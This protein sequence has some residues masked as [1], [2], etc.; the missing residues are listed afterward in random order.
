MLD[1]D[2]QIFDKEPLLE[3]E[4][5][6]RAPGGKY[7]MICPSKNKLQLD[8]SH[9]SNTQSRI[10]KKSGQFFNSFPHKPSSAKDE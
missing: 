5:A 6:I 10:L 7:E 4:I 2:A 8:F 1:K 3:H 9:F